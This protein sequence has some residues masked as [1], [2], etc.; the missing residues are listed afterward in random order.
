MRP[1]TAG[2]GCASTACSNQRLSA[3]VGT[4]LFH[5]AKASTIACIS[6]SRP[7]PVMADTATSGTPFI[8]MSF[9]SACSRNLPMAPAVFSFRSHLLTAMTMARPSCST[10][11]AMRWSCSSKAFSDVEQHHHD[12]GEAHRVERIGNRQLFQLLV[13]A[14]AAPNAGGI[15]DAEFLAMPVEIDRDGVARGAG[16]RRGQQALLADQPVDQRGFAGIRASDNGDADRMRSGRFGGSLRRL[17]GLRRQRSAQRIVEI[18][19]ALI[20]LGGNRHR[21]AEA[22]R[23]GIQPPGFAGGAFH[24]VGDQHGRLAGFAHQFGEGPVGRASAR[25]ARR[26]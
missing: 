16:F 25:R 20:V 26:S 5:T 17:R 24:L 6:R 12:F 1:D 8:C 19:Q 10:R 11:S 2:G 23:I 14:P 7:S 3:E 15:V 18:G 22:E 9:S 4:R 13:D 21:I